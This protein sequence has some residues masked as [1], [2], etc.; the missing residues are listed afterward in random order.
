[1]KKL[2]VSLALVMLVFAGASLFAV[3]YDNNEYQRKSRAYSELAVKSYDDGDYD[4]ATEYARLAEENATLS[5]A[6]IEKMIARSDADNALR[7]AHARLDWARDVR[8]EKF[9]P[10]AYASASGSIVSG[11]NLFASED[12]VSA[13]QQADAALD[14]LSVVREV[15]PLPALY[16]VEK[17]ISTRDC[18]WNI[19]KNPA[20]YGDPLLW[21]ELYKANKSSLKHPADPNL[22]SPG[23]VITIPSVAGEYREGTY[24]PTIKYAPFVNPAKKLKK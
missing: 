15:T 2:S 18:L 14:S 3:T 5:A 24:D 12:Y 8:A 4:A 11:D 13:K 1:M 7:T 20:V 21:S 9:F 23:M 22:L 19:A 10:D 16:K 6:F 17:W